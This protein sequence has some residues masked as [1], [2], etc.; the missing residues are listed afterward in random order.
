MKMEGITKFE[1]KGRNWRN[2]LI[3]SYLALFSPHISLRSVVCIFTKI[4]PTLLNIFK[5]CMK[6]LYCITEQ[7]KFCNSQKE[8]KILLL[9][10]GITHI[11]YIIIEDIPEKIV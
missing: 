1:N 4:F 9:M 8:P 6:I 10:W 3:W 2:R 11:A 7:N 5:T